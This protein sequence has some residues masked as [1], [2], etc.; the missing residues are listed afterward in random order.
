MDNLPLILAGPI[1]RRVEPQLVAVWVALSHEC[2]VQL[3]LWEEGQ[4]KAGEREPWASGPDPAALTVRSGAKLHVVVVTL[5]LP[6]A[7]R[8]QPG[9]VYSYDLKLQNQIGTHTL[10]SLGLLKDVTSP[11]LSRVH[12]ALGYETDVLPSFALPPAALTELRLVHG[13]CRRHGF[14]SQDGLAWV[15]DLISKDK[16]YTNAI[17]R[18]HQLFLTG[19][20]IYADDVVQAQLHALIEAGATLLGHPDAAEPAKQIPEIP[21]NVELKNIDPKKLL[22]GNRTPLIMDDAGMTTSGSSH[23]ITWAEFCAMYLASWSNVVWPD[24]LPGVETFLTDDYLLADLTPEELADPVL[25]EAKRQEREKERREKYPGDQLAPLQETLRTLPKVRRALANVPT[26]MMFDDH[27]V[28]DDWYLNPTWRDRVLTNELGRMIVRNGLLSYALFQGWGNDPIKFE[29]EPGNESRPH[30]ELL[31]HAARL[32][33]ANATTQTITDEKKKI[34]DLLGL[35]QRVQMGANG[36]FA[37]TNP[38]LKWHYSLT[39]EEFQVV[40]L[41]CR[42]RR[43]F[44]SR[45][46]PPGN[47]AVNAMHEQLPAGPLPDGKKILFVVASLPVLGPPIFDALLAP[48]LY[49]VFD[50]KSAGELQERRGTKHLV[51]TNP[52]AVEAWSFDPKTF[53]ALLARLASYRR[54]VLLSGDVH[55]GAANV[56]SYWPKD[57]TEPPARFAQFISS[58]MRNVMPEKVTKIS[59]SFAIAQRMIRSELG[60]EQLAWEQES[61]AVLTVPPNVNASPRLRARLRQ[62]PALVPT[63][64]WPTGVVEARPPDWAWRVD[65]LNDTRADKDR[66][67]ATKPTTL[68]PGEPDKQT[69]DIT[70]PDLAGYHRVAHRHARQ[71]ERLNNSRQI[72][73]TS[74]IGVVTFQLSEQHPG[75]LVAVQELYAAHPDPDKLNERPP[76][77][78]YARYEAELDDNSGR[79]RPKI[80]LAPNS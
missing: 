35:N 12:L 26:Y 43:S 16:A 21:L 77:L 38:P 36:E 19:D 3:S 52:D 59:R 6:A 20:Q 18:P 1:L 17:K 25:L 10:Q 76:P 58:G 22:P 46:S 67:N 29:S 34:D 28:T 65:W 74:N 24:E 8:L 64:G 53:E 48:L 23:L 80:P 66:P 70:A 68:F 57:M 2:G 13:S 55:Y 33:A 32:F 73:F 41:D 27:E 45:I 63:R 14:Q 4:V 44:V 56:M 5:K 7:K 75:T 15:D 69:A 47:V 40:V 9:R 62:S 60:A 79:G 37:E 61:P 31:D 30:K 11:L 51:G 50:F 42:T 54:V 72:L 39:G 49:R 71:L 78:V